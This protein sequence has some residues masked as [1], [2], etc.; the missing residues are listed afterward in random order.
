MKYLKFRYVVGCEGGK[1][2]ER[3]FSL[4]MMA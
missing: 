4:L 1:V 3:D 2:G